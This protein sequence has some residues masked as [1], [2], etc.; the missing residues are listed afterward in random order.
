LEKILVLPIPLFFAQPMPLSEEGFK[1]LLQ[2]LQ[3]YTAYICTNS[4]DNSD[5]LKNVKTWRGQ[6]EPLHVAKLDAAALVIPAPRRSLKRLG[7][8]Q[9]NAS[10]RAQV[11]HFPSWLKNWS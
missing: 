8:S 2:N 6:P 9:R 3:I 5:L 10:R 7:K 11:K 1:N 4:T